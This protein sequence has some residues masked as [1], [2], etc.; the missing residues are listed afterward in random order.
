MNT[1]RPSK[2]PQSPEAPLKDEHPNDSIKKLAVLFTDVVG[3]TK[4]FKSRGNLEGRKML[5]IHQ[6]LVSE[7]ILEH[8]GILVK[9]LGDSVMAYFEDP[10]EAIKSAIKIQKRFSDYNQKEAE[11]DQI[12]IRIGIHFGYAIIEEKD[13]FGDAVNMAA[14]LVQVVGRDEVFISQ[15]VYDL[16]KN[17]S[18]GLFQLVNDLDYKKVPKELTIYKVLWDETRALAL[19]THILVHLR[20]LPNWNRAPFVEVWN[21]LLESKEH[22]WKDKVLEEDLLS[23]KS[24]VLVVKEPSSSLS[25]AKDVLAFLRKELGQEY[26]SLPPPM[27][28]VIDATTSPGTHKLTPEA[29]ELNWDELEPGEVYVSAFAYRFLGDTQSVSIVPSTGGEKPGKFHKI[30]FDE[31]QQDHRSNLFL[32][33]AAL[34]QGD[35]P[36]CF[37]C[38]DRRHR[39]LDCPSKQ[40]LELTDALK[41]LG[42]LSLEK[43]NRLFY[44]YLSGA[45]TDHG[46]GSEADYAVRS[47][48]LLAYY[49]VYELKMIFQL[50]FFRTIW[51]SDVEDWQKLK[52]SK[53]H[54]EKGGLVWLG[55]DCIRV[56]NLAQ[57]EVL[58]KTFRNKNPEDYKVDCAMGFLHME[59]NQFLRARDSFENALVRAKTN[60]QRIF[61]LFLLA[62]LHNLNHH[63]DKAQERIGEILSLYP[64]CTEAI[65]GDILLKLRKGIQGAALTRLV[66]LIKSDSTYYVN[67]LI[68]P[69]LAPY[70]DI[71]HPELQSLLTQARAEAKELV[72]KA[73]EALGRLRSI[74]GDNE[75]EVE[76]AQT[77][78]SKIE[79]LLKTD[80]YPG[81]IDVIYYA[82][83]VIP[84]VETSLRERR[85]KVSEALYELEERCQRSL[86]VARSFPFRSLIKTIQGSLDHLQSKLYEMRNRLR[87]NDI[88]DGFTK[89]TSQLEGLRED[90]HDAE[91]RLE[92]M[93]KI[94]G[95]IHFS[96]R[97]IRKSI[98]FQL[99]NFG[100]GLIFLPVL[101]YYL[102]LIM[103]QLLTYRNIWLYQKTFLSIGGIL[104]LLLA[105]FMAARSPQPK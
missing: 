45:H 12:H 47:S 1:R 69:E 97:F 37:Y 102:T 63:P 105:L 95:I 100:F 35:G 68:D 84:I 25:L 77:Q 24:V 8:G 59:R 2:A 93:D 98:I 38:G 75:S 78:W 71:I 101:V 19:I 61:L 66:K 64:Q 42:Y 48:D 49:A 30:V 36:P 11:G 41:K 34:A 82:N 9:T 99:F 81:Y 21:H 16:V 55:Q 72:P 32:Y 67:A 86:V 85:K 10:R 14:K 18:H 23:D 43:I 20:P 94:K 28:I 103:P 31:H 5:Q 57:A 70:R 6:T 91:M 7:S 96:Y 79:E 13:I 40:I 27:H 39:S 83:S 26:R 62:R 58:L 22:L 104:G 88:S 4:Y 90:L 15:E 60:P 51:N 80:S 87:H 17:L 54:Q 53:A 56:A 92:R 3:S 29:S 73:R 74:L 52:K 76:R 65:Y 33:Q 44:N 50:R 46:Q 89:A